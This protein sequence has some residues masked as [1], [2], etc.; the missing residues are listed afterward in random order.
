MPGNDK[1][2]PVEVEVFVHRITM[3]DRGAML[4]SPDG[5]ES[6]ARWIPRSQVID[7]DRDQAGIAANG[8]RLTEYRAVLTLPFWL[9]REKGLDATDRTEGL[10]DLFGGNRG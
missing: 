10:D 8:G 6:R 4:V 7:E 3:G 1:T 5:D 9:A 2:A